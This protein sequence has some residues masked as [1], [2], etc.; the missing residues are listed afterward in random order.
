MN[1]S[2]REFLA[3]VALAVALAPWRK[4]GAQSAG[5]ST[6]VGNFRYI[7][8]DTETRTEF[9]NFLINVFHL[10][11]E[12]DLQKLIETAATAGT[13]DE[14]IYR[15][16]QARLGTIKPLLGDLTYSLPALSKQK[17]VLADQTLAL[18]GKGKRYDGYLEVGSNGRFYDSLT[19]R[20]NI[21][22]T[23]FTMTD[24]A[25]TYGL[26]DV[27]DRGQIGK[28]GGFVALNDYKPTLAKQIPPH[29]VDLA[30][31]FIGFHHC[32]I[33]LRD[34]FIGGIRDAIRPGGALVV[35]DHNAYDERMWRMVALA[36]DVFNM[37]TQQT[38]DYN[39]RERRNFYGLDALHAMLTRLGFRSDGRRLLQ[40]GDPTLNTLMLYTKA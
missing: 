38:W 9:K 2:K 30:T 11:P 1:P 16:V 19:E 13:S 22:G 23:S 15:A 27:L 18:L 34:E 25:P 20:L 36:H 35:R 31:V 17:N 33:D 8:R 21:V 4:V 6:T 5:D 26:V 7:Y 37:G 29:S 40:D 12:D 14:E 32:P 39:A 28:V 10:Y 3:A 24:T